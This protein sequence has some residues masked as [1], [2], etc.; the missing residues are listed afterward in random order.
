MLLLG[1]LLVPWLMVRTAS[2]QG[3]GAV[4]IMNPPAH[5]AN[6]QLR[7]AS[8]VAVSV[9]GGTQY[10]Q[11]AAS[12]STDT[13]TMAGVMRQDTPSIISGVADGDVAILKTDALGNLR[14]HTGTITVGNLAASAANVILRDTT[15]AYVSPGAG[16]QY[17]QGVAAGTTDSVTMSGVMRQDR[18]EERRVGKEGRSRWSPYH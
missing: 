7:D 11:G 3:G 1:V 6:V 16:V 5:P 9:G 8:G 18:S 4:V 15:G 10:A 12:G 14:V 2:S 13:V 17:A